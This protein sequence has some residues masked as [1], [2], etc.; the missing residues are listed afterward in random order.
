[1]E[2]FSQ[3]DREHLTDLLANYFDEEVV[4]GVAKTLTKNIQPVESLKDACELICLHGTDVRNVLNKKSIKK[5]VLFKYLHTCKVAASTRFTKA[6]LIEDII[7]FWALQDSQPKPVKDETSHQPE[8]QHVADTENFPINLMARQ[9]THWF[10]DRFNSNK[11]SSDDFWGDVNIQITINY[12]DE[13]DERDASGSQEAVHMLNQMKSDLN[14]FFNACTLHQGCQGRIDIHGLVLVLSCGTI[15]TPGLCVGVFETVFKL[16]RD[17]FTENNWK[18]KG[19]NFVLRS[20][21]NAAAVTSLMEFE[22]LRNL[23]ALP[24]PSGDI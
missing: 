15:H 13:I 9:F 7:N 19:A 16:M 14:L 2:G 3:K 18:L 11:L 1:M 10:F 23:M 21:G 8:S 20:K 24:A 4:I 17:P 5:E 12:E 22:S 6:A